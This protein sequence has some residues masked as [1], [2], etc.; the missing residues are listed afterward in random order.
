MNEQPSDAAVSAWVALVR[1]GQG[2]L[3]AVESDLKAAGFPPLAWYDALLELRGTG[4]AGLRQ[5]EL[6]RRMLLA[7]YSVS[8][9]VDRLARAGYLLR[10]PSPEDARSSQLTLT[11][12]GRDLQ[13][14]MWPTYAAA[15][16]RRLGARLNDAEALELARLLDKLRR[17]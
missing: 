13:K 9:L 12:E 2:V 16:E 6:E 15:I 8:R 7:Q 11:T 3:A 4:D 5:A 17:G 10:R 1:A 14:R